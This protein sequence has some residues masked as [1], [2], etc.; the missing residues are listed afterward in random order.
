M[1]DLF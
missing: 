1:Q